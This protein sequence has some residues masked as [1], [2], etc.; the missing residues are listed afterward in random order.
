MAHEVIYFEGITYVGGRFFGITKDRETAQH[1]IDDYMKRNKNKPYNLAYNNI[2][3][4]TLIEQNDID[5]FTQFLSVCNPRGY[6][7]LSSV[8]YNSLC[9]TPKDPMKAIEYYMK[10]KKTTLD[11]A[12]NKVLQL[13]KAYGNYIDLF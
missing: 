10:K 13:S 2:I 12:K 5:V 4:T 11:I 8:S 9:I 1:I 6:V 7:L 3:N